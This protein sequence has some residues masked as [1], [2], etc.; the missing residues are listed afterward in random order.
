LV[1]FSKRYARKQKWVFFFLTQWTMPGMGSLAMPR[2]VD[3]LVLTVSLYHSL[4]NK[5]INNALIVA[6]IIAIICYKKKKTAHML[7]E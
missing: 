5:I 7:H 2:A 4:V 1:T 3:F 6:L